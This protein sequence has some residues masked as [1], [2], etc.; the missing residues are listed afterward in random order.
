[1]RIGRVSASISFL[2][3]SMVG[4]VLASGSAFVFAAGAVEP[5][6]DDLHT[7]V[8][9]APGGGRVGVDGPLF[10]VA[11]GGQPGGADAVADQEAHDGARARGGQ[12]PVAGE[13]GG[14][15][16]N[17]VGVAFDGDRVLL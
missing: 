4:E 11:G 12:L 9:R 7:P 8:L 5:A 17:V 14:V 6:Q 2:F 10:G 16:G 1:M 15:D 13:L 3:L